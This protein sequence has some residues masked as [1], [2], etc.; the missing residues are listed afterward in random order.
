MKLVALAIAT[1]GGAGFAPVAPGTFG[2]AVGLAIFFLTR[3]WPLW[4]QLTGVLV[5]SV[6]GIWACGEAARHFQR[7]D[8]GQAV[9]DEVAGQWLSCLATVAAAG[10]AG[11]VTAFVLFRA[12]DIVKPWPV[13]R[14]ESLPSGLGIMADDLAAGV[15]ANI[16]LQLVGHWM[17][18]LF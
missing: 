16:V 5:V 11:L 6:V 14:F 3:H 7:H 4:T 1:A 12:F 17:P 8:P 15:Y 18:G 10:T 2:S 9:V 13:R